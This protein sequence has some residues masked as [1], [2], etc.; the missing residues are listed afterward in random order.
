MHIFAS[1]IMHIA[2]S[3]FYIV[4]FLSDLNLFLVFF[5]LFSLVLIVCLYVSLPATVTSEFPQCGMNKG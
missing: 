5:V 1:C 2:Y 3:T 4:S